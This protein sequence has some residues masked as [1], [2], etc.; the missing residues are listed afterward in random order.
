MLLGVHITGEILG[1]KV[2][3]DTLIYS[4]AIMGGILGISYLLTRNLKIEAHNLKQTLLETLWGLINGLTS[5]Q[6]PGDKGKNFIPLI[7]GIF[8]FTIFAYWLGLMPWKI[9]EVFNF[10]PKLD[11]GEP[12][13][14]SSPAANINVTLGMALISLVTYILAGIK[15]GGVGYILNYFKPLGFVE[16]LDLLV[17]PLTLSLRLFANTIA[18]EVLVVSVLGLVALVVPAVALAFELFVGLIQALVFSL[19]TTVY[20]GTAMA[21]SEHRPKTKD[22]RP[23]LGL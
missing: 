4:W 17:R 20:I 10:W 23:F 22:H 1:Q 5:S 12:W 13:E 3:M 6:I 14:G 8:I 15:N 18:G 21:H 7:G 19:L 11:N 16:W 2:H 9:G